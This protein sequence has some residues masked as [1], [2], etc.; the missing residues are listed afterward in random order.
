[1]T[2]FLFPPSQISALRAGSSKSRQKSLQTIWA[3]RR[4]ELDGVRS[5]LG[6]L[7]GLD[8]EGKATLQYLTRAGVSGP[9][10]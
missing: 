3:G 7:S 6:W 8:Q 1:M 10:L 5:P 2:V 4:L 9:S